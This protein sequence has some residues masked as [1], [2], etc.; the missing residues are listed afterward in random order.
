MK[1]QGESYWYWGTPFGM[2]IEHLIDLGEDNFSSRKGI[3][4]FNQF[5]KEA[6]VKFDQ[7]DMSLK[8]PDSELFYCKARIP[9][10]SDFGK[11]WSMYRPATSMKRTRC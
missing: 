8:G 9:I 5:Y 1:D 2:L 10:F 7:N 11:S 4:D 3:S 6:R